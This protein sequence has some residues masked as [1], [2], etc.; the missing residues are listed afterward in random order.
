MADMNGCGGRLGLYIRVT[1][2]TTIGSTTTMR[3]PKPQQAATRKQRRFLCSFRV[4]RSRMTT[5]V[6]GWQDAVSI[7]VNCE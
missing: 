5:R 3:R 6:S 2:T 1:S 4:R 7:T